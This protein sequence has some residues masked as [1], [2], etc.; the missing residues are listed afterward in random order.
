MKIKVERINDAFQLVGINENG[1]QVAIDASTNVGGG[2]TAFRPMQLLL[3]GLASCSAIDILNIL[4]KQKQEVRSFEV[5]VEGDRT[6]DIP[7]IFQDIRVLIKA[8]GSLSA[9]KLEKAIRLTKEKYCSVYH[10]LEASASINYDYEL[11]E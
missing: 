11:K 10:I 1:N 7:S 2:D 9:L 3:V 8:S 5:E 4:Y 6:D